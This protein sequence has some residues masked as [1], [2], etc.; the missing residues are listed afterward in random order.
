MLILIM[1]YFLKCLFAAFLVTVSG[2]LSMSISD[3]GRECK[4]S[5]VCDPDGLLT[6][7]EGKLCYD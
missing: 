3:I 7:D 1:W 5:Y 2:V 6:D 4:S